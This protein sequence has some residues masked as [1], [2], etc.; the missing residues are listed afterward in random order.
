MRAWWMRLW[1][2]PSVLAEELQVPSGRYAEQRE[3]GFL[4]LRFLD[5]L[6]R[7]YQRNFLTLNAPAVR[8]AHL[9]GIAGILGFIAL[10]LSTLR[11]SPASVYQVLLLVSLP[12]LLVPFL[13]TF[14]RRGSISLQRISFLST[15]VL[16]LSIAWVVWRG[17]TVHADYP[18]ESVI[19]VTTYLYFLSGL[20]WAQTVVCGLLIWLAFM[21]PALA[22]GMPADPT[23]LYDAFY[24]LIANV[25]GMVGR[26]VFEYQDRVQFLMRLELRH[27]A[28]KDALTGLMNRRAFSHHAQVAWAQALREHKTVS[29]LILDLDFLKRINDDYGHLTGD[30]CLRQVA[31]ALRHL[32]RR[33]LDAAS[34]YG[35]DEFLAL[36]YDADPNWIEQIQAEFNEQ[37]ARRDD[38]SRRVER[39]GVTGGGVICRP[40][41]HLSF[42][43][44]LATADE[45]LYGGKERG[46]G[47]ISW[48]QLPRPPT[49]EQAPALGGPLFPGHSELSI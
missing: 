7:E 47:V 6:E 17:G 21:A 35:G 14:Q 9:L 15:L 49:P 38:L 11:L 48:V 31:D 29:L 40:N 41:P 30:A 34:R 28:E 13:A 4:L 23:L 20:L 1:T 22:R 8:A 36:W 10:D 45:Q 27:L 26:Y 46:R 16:G 43:D 3:K 12:A 39:L 19:V 42:M 32:T 37:L 33:P 25:I 2:L 24:L 5:D 44:A 18:T